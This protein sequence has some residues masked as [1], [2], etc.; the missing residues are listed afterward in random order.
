MY[1]LPA[2][3]KTWNSDP[4]KISIILVCVCRRCC[5]LNRRFFPKL[6]SSVQQWNEGWRI[7]ALHSQCVK[8]FSCCVDVRFA[9]QK[10]GCLSVIMSVL[11]ILRVPPFI[12]IVWW[13]G[14]L[15][16]CE[17]MPLSKLQSGLFA[18]SMLLRLQCQPWL[19]RSQ[20][21]LCMA[22]VFHWL[23]AEKYFSSELSRC[24][25]LEC[26]SLWWFGFFF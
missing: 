24:W 9:S 11:V 5:F 2:F 21:T 3:L 20:S 10:E 6:I 13:P 23:A 1:H 22:G 15:H 19:Q 25:V 14:A 18:K 16:N 8:R 7:I 12:S 17:F 26:A 4:E